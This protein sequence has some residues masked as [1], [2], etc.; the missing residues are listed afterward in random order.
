VRE[1]DFDEKM[2]AIGD[3]AGKTEDKGMVGSSQ[4]GKSGLTI[5]RTPRELGGANLRQN[6]PAVWGGGL[7]TGPAE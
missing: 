2:Y 3:G 6:A 1:L 7:L 4:E 5:T